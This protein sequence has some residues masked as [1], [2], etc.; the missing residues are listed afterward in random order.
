MAAAPGLNFLAAGVTLALSGALLALTT[1]YVP[2]PYMDEPFHVDV[3]ENFCRGQFTYQNAKVTTP[4][5]LYIVSVVLVRRQYCNLPP[6]RLTT[7][8]VFYPHRH[9]PCPAGN[10]TPLF[11]QARRVPHPL[12]IRS[13]CVVPPLVPPLCRPHFPRGG[14]ALGNVSST[15]HTSHAN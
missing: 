13:D 3:A 6:P 1:K 4:P 10:C 12:T 15:R 5:G 14:A 8:K 11:R 9:S 7:G 2:D